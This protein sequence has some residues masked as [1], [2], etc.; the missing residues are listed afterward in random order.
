MECFQCRTTNPFQAKFCLECGAR[1]E[2]AVQKAVSL[3]QEPSGPRSERRL[4]TIFFT[5]L[6]GY[7]SLSERMDP[8][9][10]HAIINRIF[11]RFEQIIKKQGGYVDK[12]MGD[13]LMSVFGISQ[14]HEDDPARAVL[15]G[16]EMIEELKKISAELKQELL[17]RTGINTGE[18]LWGG[19]ASGGATVW[20]DTVN[21][22]QRLQVSAP[23]DSI[24]ISQSTR[25]HL[26]DGFRLR[27]IPSLKLDGKEKFVQAYEVLGLEEK[28][29]VTLIP[30]IGRVN[31][32][33]LLKIVLDETVSK[34][35]P[36]FMTIYGEAGI[37]KSRLIQE[38][39]K[40]VFDR[41]E[42]FQLFYEQCLPQAQLPYDP[43]AQIIRH[44]FDLGN[45][46]L[47]EA[48]AR[49][50]K[51]SAKMF[52]DEPLAHHFFGFFVGMKYPDSPLEELDSAAA[53]ASS[54]GT[55]KK[56]L[57][58][59]SREKSAIILIIEDLQWA[60]VGT[61][62]FLE[63]LPHSNFSGPL[64]IITTVRPQEK[65]SNFLQRVKGT[66]TEP[67]LWKLIELQP[68]TKET[69]EQFVDTLL[70]NIP[71]PVRLKEEL[72]IKTGGN[73][74]FLE[75]LIRGWS[76]EIESA[77]AVQGSR[78]GEMVIPENIW[79]ILESRIDRL[80]EREKR[81]LK[82][83]SVFG[84]IFW[85]QGVRRCLVEDI[86]HE[87]VNLEIKGFISRSV[88]SLYKNDRE[89]NFRHELIR[90]VAYR[91]ILKKERPELHKGVLDFL[92]EKH[93]NNEIG[94]ELYLKLSGHH[95]EQAREFTEALTLYET[96]GDYESNRYMLPEAIKV[97]I[98][99]RELL[100][101]ADLKEPEVKK[102][103]LLEKEAHLYLLLGCYK[104][105]GDWYERLRNEAPHWSWRV[106][107]LLGLGEI[108]DK[109]GEYDLAFRLA[110]EGTE[111]AYHGKNNRLLGQ[112]LNLVSRTLIGKGLYDGSAKLS[113][114]VKI[115]FTKIMT[116][117]NL[118]DNELKEA[119]KELATSFNNIALIQWYQ[120]EYTYALRA[121]RDSFKIMQEIG[122]RYGIAAAYINIGNV[123]R[124]QGDYPSALNN[125]N[126]SCQ[127]NE[128][129]GNRRGVALA[130]LNIGGVYHD[131]GDY[132]R[133]LE[134]YQKGL[135][136][137]RDIGDYREESTALSNIG[138]LY[139]DQG[140]YAPSL[141]AHLESL[142]LKKRLADRAEL[143][144]AL[145]N[146][147]TLYFE[148]GEYLE[149]G[150]LIA[151]AE[152]L[153]KDV[154]A[155]MEI[156]SCLNALGRIMVFFAL[157]G[158]L[159][160]LTQTDLFAKARHYAQEAQKM[161]KT[162]NLK[163]QLL[164]AI[165]TMA[166]VNIQEATWLS[167]GNVRGEIKNQSNK[168]QEE[169]FRE[170]FKFLN[171]GERLLPYIHRKESEIHYLFTRTRYYLER[172]KIMPSQSSEEPS[173]P[174]SEL[175]KKERQQIIT[176][177]VE[178]ASRALNIT[179]ELGIRRLLPEAMYLYVE[180]LALTGE[181]KKAADYYDSCRHLAEMMGLKPFLRMA[182]R[183]LT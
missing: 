154:R 128:K 90:D 157:M 178:T 8:E 181:K 119:R 87:L 22:A 94:L 63:H 118:G 32:L 164:G 182:A 93:N 156:V 163:P 60:D 89:Y 116:E 51:E 159:P 92:K 18:V 97:Y 62:D 70:K 167:G 4:A 135:S 137:T 122:N 98:K 55:I 140:E 113:E 114:R 79:Q 48:K 99:A 180:A 126:E 81:V 17:M 16:L 76:E 82:M 38:F 5:D 146:I 133:S 166:L 173:G 143:V 86:S 42:S 46:S 14:T 43:L 23:I 158:G 102:A 142:K 131:Q 83:A 56:L 67:T 35:Q 74:L 9:E 26:K 21:I 3:P 179:Q 37:G 6:V 34:K 85:E 96:Y 115:T 59:V 136:I 139:H 177:V 11:S 54:F 132:P 123:Y 109:Q 50:Q 155:K 150:N 145:L 149:A 148:R 171:D 52:P 104:E 100:E 19:V 15:A 138:N 29:P 80:P 57:E 161:S 24:L 10:V 120:G 44:H 77:G 110:G 170:A 125:Y 72:W 107:G 45:L 71:L 2:E 162:L 108:A 27:Q 153:T 61:I 169:L 151:E 69:T 78:G 106:R 73:P 40:F 183:T 117:N 28:K 84:R 25:R 127:V 47:T 41:S 124:D 144:M 95:A 75:E 64:L 20:G 160:G 91:M 105:A 88:E 112:A 65:A 53:R 39:K 1:L 12:F 31:E 176:E 168:R 30:F 147:A 121:Y 68:L 141:K 174:L 172:I 101:W 58:Q 33:R 49:L 130:V 175:I 152:N 13:A 7:T 134:Y 103:V 165:T 66:E 36:S 129:I 111:I